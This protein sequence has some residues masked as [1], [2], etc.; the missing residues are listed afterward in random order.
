[1]TDQNAMYEQVARTALILGVALG[2]FIG[3]LL[4]FLLLIFI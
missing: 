2:L 1:M 3:G 4:A